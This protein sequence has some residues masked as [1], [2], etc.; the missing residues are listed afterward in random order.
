MSDT[1]S[2]DDEIYRL[3]L[4]DRLFKRNAAMYARRDKSFY[5]DDFIV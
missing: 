4:Y 5:T 2:E 1:D 3:E